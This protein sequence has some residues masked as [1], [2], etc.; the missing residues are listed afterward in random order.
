M[1]EPASIE[2][3]EAGRGGPSRRRP[4]ILRGIAG[5]PGIAIGP[6]IVVGAE[7]TPVVHRPIAHDEIPAESARFQAAVTRAQ[8]SIRQVAERMKES[9]AGASEAAILEAYVTMMGDEMV[10]D[11][12]LRRIREER[13]NVEWA[14]AQTIAEIRDKLAGSSDPYLVERQHDIAFIGERLLRALAGTDDVIALPKLPRPSVIVAQALSPADTAAMTKEPVLAIVT[15]SGTRTSHTSIMARALEIPAVVGVADVLATVSTGE[16]VIVDGLKGEIIVGPT[17]EM[18]AQA[19]RRRSRHE[20]FVERLRADRERQATMADGTVVH[21]RANIE[22]PAEVDIAIAQGAEGIG[23]FR[24][25][26]LYLERSVPP[27]E[28]EQFEIYKAIAEACAPRPVVMRTFDIG[29]DKLASAFPAPRELNPALGRRAIRLALSQPEL[30][31]EQLRAMVRASAHGDVRILLPMISTLG[32]L[33]E[34]RRLV[35]RAIE[36][37]AKKGQPHASSIPLGVMIEVP[38]AAILASAFAKEADFLSLGTNDLV[39]YTMAIDRTSRALAHMASHF[40][41]SLLLLLAQVVDAARQHEKP[42]SVCGAMASEPLA[43]LLLVGLG[44]RELSMEAAALLEIKE[45]L[46]RT[47]VAEVEAMAKVALTKTTA[48]EVETFVRSVL[49]PRLGDVLSGEATS[50]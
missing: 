8:A 37:V 18:I 13:Q 46:S 50:A 30:F 44:V 9:G 42:L 11:G 7:S 49:E 2:E 25:E 27:S 39:Q 15:E 16:M 45:A 40:E 14:V 4:R 5:S 36:E 3:G 12:V 34:A 21:L 20:A 32:E 47:T 6:C 33:R 10:E 23:L 24:T 35:H 41:P 48:Q 22:L 31:L 17:P 43:A 29:G 38:S 26:L 28:E 19:E 1:K